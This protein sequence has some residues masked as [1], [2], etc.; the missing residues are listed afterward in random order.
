MKTE[1]LDLSKINVVN[2]LDDSI[3]DNTAEVQEEKENTQ[4]N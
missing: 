2:L 4:D 3:P 1:K